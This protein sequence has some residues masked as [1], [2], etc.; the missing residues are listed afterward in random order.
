[1]IRTAIFATQS[2]DESWLFIILKIKNSE[3]GQ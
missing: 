3:M 1:M 2:M